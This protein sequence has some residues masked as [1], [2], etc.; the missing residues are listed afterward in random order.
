L[1][2]DCDKVA[3]SVPSF[4][5]HKR[6]PYLGIATAKY[7]ELPDHEGNLLTLFCYD[8]RKPLCGVCSHVSHKSHK[9][10]QI[11]KSII[12][13]KTKL[14]ALLETHQHQVTSMEAEIKK[15]RKRFKNGT[16]IS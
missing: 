12:E 11:K 6:F 2:E 14:E 16:F 5:S 8:C 1:C 13:I 10:M 7:C 15:N 3:H 9:V 4:K